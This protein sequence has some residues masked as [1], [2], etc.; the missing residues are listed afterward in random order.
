MTVFTV[1]C[2]FFPFPLTSV[3]RK[4]KGRPREGSTENTIRTENKSD[5]MLFAALQHK[6]YKNSKKIMNTPHSYRIMTPSSHT[7]EWSPHLIS[8]ND[9]LSLIHKAARGVT[10]FVYNLY[11]HFRFL[12][13]HLTCLSVT[14]YTK[15][16]NI[17]YLQLFVALP[18]ASLVYLIYFCPICVILVCVGSKYKRCG[19]SL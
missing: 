12:L 19:L 7:E 15:L 17:L 10:F 3:L 5:R 1:I 14:C 9:A 8:K 18:T 11:Y 13:K 6:L 2:L 16:G 4:Q